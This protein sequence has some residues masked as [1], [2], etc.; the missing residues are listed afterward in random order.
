MTTIEL[1]LVPKYSVHIGYGLLETIKLEHQNIAVFADMALQGVADALCRVLEP[2]GRVRLFLLPSGEATKQMSIYADSLSWLSSEGFGRDGAILA[3]GGGATSDLAGFVAATFLRGLP[4]YIVPTTLLAIVDASVGGKTAI[5]LPEGK[6]LVGAF[7]QPSGVWASLELLSTLPGREFRSGAAELFKHGLLAR[8][9]LCAKVLEP[10]FGP[11]TAD[12]EEILAR[13]VEVKAELVVRD[14]QDRGVRT[15]LNFGHTLAHALEGLT[16]YEMPHGEAVAYGMHY[17]AL[18]SE[19]AGFA[20]LTAWTRAFL[21]YQQPMR[22]P[23]FPW[24]QLERFIKRDKKAD[25]RGVRYVLLEDLARPCVQYVPNH[26]QH[27]A[28]ER[29]CGDGA[30]SS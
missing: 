27:L 23:K 17:A 11:H 7:H 28:W 1:A 14:S 9:E 19:L 20:N 21:D 29:L 12:L 15:V 30:E 4:F 25:S 24:E 6:N 18:L 16:A 22:L 13:A 26:L 2:A 5:N 10:G 8:P 3:L